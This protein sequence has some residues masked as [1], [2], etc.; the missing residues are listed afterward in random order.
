MHGCIHGGASSTDHPSQELQ[1]GLCVQRS[2]DPKSTQDLLTEDEMVAVQNNRHYIGCELNEEYGELIDSRMPIE[3][4][5]QKV[6]N[7][8]TQA[9]Y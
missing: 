5:S 9:L 8:L 7:P 2:H 6:D 3:I 4:L 1:R